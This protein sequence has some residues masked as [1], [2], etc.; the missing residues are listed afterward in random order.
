MAVASVNGGGVVRFGV[1]E[2]DLRAGEL[3]RNGS[4]VRLQDQP[5]QILTTLLERPGE[6]VSRDELREKLWPSDTFVDFDHSLN[7][8]VRRLRDALGDSADSPRFVETVAR[9]GYRFVAPVSPNYPPSVP[10][11]PIPIQMSRWKWPVVLL[12]VAVLALG[13]MVGWHAA[14]RRQSYRSPLPFNERRLTANPEEVPVLSS[15]ISP[16]G[17]YLAFADSTGF[18]LRQIE[19]GETH[20]LSLP[21]GFN[22]EPAAWFPDGGHLLATWVPGPK[23]L[24]SLWEISVLGGAPRKIRDAAYSAAVSPDGSQI[25]FLTGP[26]VRP[27]LWLM[28]SDGERAHLLYTGTQFLGSPAWSPDGRRLAYVLATYVPGTIAGLHVQIEILDFSTN[29]ASAVLSESRL[30]PGLAWTPDNRLLFSMTELPPNQQDSNL[31]SLTLSPQTAQP[32][33]APTRLT[34]D[35]GN[36]ADIHL[37][38]NGKRAAFSKH[39]LQPDVYLA[40]LEN[41]GTRLSAPRRLTLD[42]RQDY[43]FS[44]T[45]DSK[46]VIFVSDRDGTFHIFEQSPDQSAPDLLVGGSETIQAPRLTPD[47]LSLLYLVT[48]DLEDA[49]PITR[50]MRMPLA[51]GPPQLVLEGRG[52]SNHQCARSP[53]TLCIYSLMSPQQARFF[54]FDP[55]KGEGPELEK[56]NIHDLDPYS[57]NWTLSPDG[58]TMAFAKKLSV[59][60]E[61]AIR[62]FSLANNTERILKLHDWAG[63]ANLDWA[64]DGK[65]IWATAFTTTNTWTLLNINLQGRVRPML[66]STKMTIG[67]AIPSP[68]GRHLALWQASGSSNVWM[69]ENF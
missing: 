6:V 45:A 37:T 5:F 26:R 32:I 51:G 38:K 63:I 21:K 20:Q 12:V 40:D 36:I 62:I 13:V 14:T 43:Q 15:A 33:G 59:E 69:I 23:E 60:N 8:A 9:R 55:I 67:W 57:F 47:G 34:R 61:P 30:G 54:T 42:D 35:P 2:V 7:A 64:A 27:Q 68:D 31:W 28:Q 52:I 10:A 41:H 66:E 56:A 46:S 25:A 1:F 16:D 18:Y 53:S 17:R 39:A 29:Q 65:S 50:L 24:P 11:A 44:W 58:Q 4:K 49:A 19:T 3:K 22:A 48:S